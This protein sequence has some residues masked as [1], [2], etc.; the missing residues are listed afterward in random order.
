MQ[1]VRTRLLERWRAGGSR[2]IV[3]AV[4][5]LTS[6]KELHASVPSGCHS[7]LVSDAGHT[8]VPAVPSRCL[9][10]SDLD[11]RW[12]RSCVIWIRY[13]VR[14]H[15]IAV[16]PSSPDGATTDSPFSRWPCQ[17]GLRGQSIAENGQGEDR[18]SG[19]P[20]SGSSLPWRRRVSPFRG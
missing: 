11:G 6:M 17:T 4:D 20:C 12:I 18:C 16:I 10:F 14:C 7:H 8:E 15:G 3:L 5:D 1:H 13:E 2:K 9:A 19:R